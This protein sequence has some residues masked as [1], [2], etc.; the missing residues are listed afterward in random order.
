MTKHIGNR[1]GS[2]VNSITNSGGI[3]NSFS[4]YFFSTYSRVN[5]SG[6]IVST[7]GNGWIYHTFTS[8]GQFVVLAAGFVE[9][10][11]VGGGG[12]AGA[13][14]GSGGGGGGIVYH[15]RFAI[16]SGTYPVTVGSGGG[17]SLSGQGTPGINPTGLKGGD[18]SFGSMTAIGGG[19]GSPFNTDPAGT[20][21]VS[22]GSGGGYSVP[23]GTG[24]AQQPTANSP[25]IPDT[26]F[27]QYGFA[28][29]LAGDPI[30]G[31]GGG[32]G[33][34]GGASGAGI[35]GVG[36][37]FPDFL[38]PLI[39]LP[40]LAPLNGFFGGGG[41]AGS[42]GTPLAGGAGGGGP[43]TPAAGVGLDGAT[44]WGAP[45]V[46]YSGGGGGGGWYSTTR[47]GTAGVASGGPGLV[48][49]RY[50]ITGI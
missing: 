21:Q 50:N 20:S 44:P 27:S 34:A 12:G 2:A 48:V 13:P 17:G 14:L 16:N 49:I 47:G 19:G 37:Q 45:G 8:P 9:V 15:R 24:V 4:H 1:I 41:A 25:F 26:N 28:G 32:A 3:F 40:S 38:G 10:L 46:Q 36:K 11:M 42:R 31:A 29:S 7:P 30:G 22:G 6:G 43:S 18:S 5:G 39:G 35:G 23:S 33:G